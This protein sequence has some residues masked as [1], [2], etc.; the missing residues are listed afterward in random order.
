MASSIG[1]ASTP[2][3]KLLGYRLSD[4]RVPYAHRFAILLSAENLTALECIVTVAKIGLD[5]SCLWEE[6]SEG[7]A[8][9]RSPVIS[10]SLASPELP[11]VVKLL[12]LLAISRSKATQQQLW[13]LQTGRS[14]AAEATKAVGC[15]L[16]AEAASSRNAWLAGT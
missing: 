4:L 7:A 11:E 12:G 10:E 5:R 13:H 15:L 3:S 2:P 9:Y 16:G 6:L 8:R 1:L 14:L